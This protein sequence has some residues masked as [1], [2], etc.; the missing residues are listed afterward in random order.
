MTEL[1]ERDIE[2]NLGEVG[3]P[4]SLNWA[5]WKV[6]SRSELDVSLSML[7]IGFEFTQTVLAS[8]LVS[9][10]M[11]VCVCIFIYI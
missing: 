10:L 2:R 6:K 9:Q 1:R 4:V 11:L 7:N 3:S 5:W 8:Y